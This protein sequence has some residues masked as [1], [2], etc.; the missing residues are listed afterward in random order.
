MHKKALTSQPETAWIFDVDGVVTN[1]DTRTVVETEILQQIIERLKRKQ[2]VALNTGRSLT[3]TIETVVQPLMNQSEDKRIFDLFFP[4]CE[5]GATWGIIRNGETSKFID[6]D[7]T[8]PEFLKIKFKKIASKYTDSMFYDETKET[9]ITTE[10]KDGVDYDKYQEGRKEFDQEVSELL[11]EQHLNDEFSL[12]SARLGSTIAFKNANK[13]LGA[14]RIFTL[15][16]QKGIKPKRFITFGDDLN[17]L[18]M[19]EEFHKSGF[20]VI[21]VNV[22]EKNQFSNVQTNFQIIDT[23]SSFDKGTLEYLTS[24]NK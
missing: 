4:V 2:P 17:D 20:E 23:I 12:V 1:N 8:P 11:L 14:K 6:P 13:G 15:L 5:F 3:W 16:E 24:F 18:E 21:H 9:N 10:I 19:G 22:G 7:F